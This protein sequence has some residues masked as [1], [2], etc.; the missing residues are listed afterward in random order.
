MEDAI[1]LQRGPLPVAFYWVENQCL[2]KLRRRA[3]ISRFVS[4][5]IR[6]Y[7]SIDIGAIW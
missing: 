4:A 1:G 5:T 6:V 2:S 7:L 3:S